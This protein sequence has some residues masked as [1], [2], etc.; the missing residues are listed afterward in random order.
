MA[1]N[2]RLLVSIVGYLVCTEAVHS[3]DLAFQAVLYRAWS[4]VGLRARIRGRHG[5]LTD[6]NCALLEACGEAPVRGQP[7]PSVKNTFQQF[8]GHVVLW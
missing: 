5:I 4:A 6:L 2:S 8:L 3:S 7:R 1:H